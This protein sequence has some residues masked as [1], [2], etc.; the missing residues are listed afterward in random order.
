M[1]INIKKLPESVQVKLSK[2]KELA[3]RGIDGEKE[4]AQRMLEML[5][6][7][8]G[9]KMEELFTDE[10]T[11][12]YFGFKATLNSLFLQLWSSMFGANERLLN[13]LKIYKVNNNRLE[14]HVPMT[15]AEYI[16]FNQMWEWHCK[17][18][19]SERRRIRKLF[20]QAYY[21][22]YSLFPISKDEAYEDYC[23]KNPSRKKKA[24]FEDLL[25]ISS[26][27]TSISRNKT[28]RKAIEE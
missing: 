1:E 6:D 14:V 7:K 2:L 23:E 13:D 9:V 26:M 24:S 16:E 3:A 8:Y 20:A 17:N 12:R 18:F 15:E 11:V 5:C 22:R 28:P 25:A 4:N 19:Q 10:K 21:E 27:S